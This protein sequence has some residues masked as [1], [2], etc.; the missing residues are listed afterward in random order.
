M[1]INEAFEV[2]NTLNPKL[3]NSNDELRTE[4]K[5]KILKVVEQFI[6]MM[7]IPVE[8]LDI[9]LVGSNCSYNYTDKSDLDVHV[10]VNYEDINL[11]QEVIQDI[12]N[13]EK[14]NFNDKFDI[15]IRGIGLEMYIQDVKSGISSNGIYSVLSDNWIKFPNKIDD[16]PIYDVGK[17]VDV[18]EDRINDALQSNEIEKV[19]RLLNNLYLMRKN[20]IAKDGEY[21]KGNQIFKELRNLGLISELKDAKRKFISKDLTLESFL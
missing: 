8:V 4:V 2:H 17:Y 11:P 16:V 12:F 10:I 15:L 7:V 6:D 9:Q 3:F 5:Q 21:G 18:W 20:S 14:S 19:Q 1:F 13:L